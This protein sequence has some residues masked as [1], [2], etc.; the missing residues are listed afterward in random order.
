M[1]LIRAEFENF[2]LLRDLV[3]DFSVDNVRKLTVIRAQNA[4]G[5]TTILNA[6]QWAL[7]GDDALPEKGKNY[8]MSPID[9]D[10]SYSTHVPISVQVDFVTTK[11][12][13]N[14]NGDSFEEKKRYRIIR[15]TYETLNATMHSRSDSI[16]KLLELT[17][18]GSQPIELAQAKIDE[19]LPIELREVFFTDGDRA[20]SFIE[21]TES[22]KV[23]RERVQN[24][25][26]SLLGLE[27]I[28]NALRHLDRTTSTFTKEVGKI[29][30]DQEIKETAE[31]LEEIRKN[32]EELEG[33]IK[34]YKSQCA[35]FEDKIVDT[36]DKID[37]ALEK[38]DQ[39][40]LK[41][42]IEQLK[43]QL[44][45]IDNDRVEANN[46]HSQ[47][48]KSLALS[49]ELLT[50]VLEKSIKKLDKL[51]EQGK[52]PSM[53]IPVLQECLDTNICICG[54]S[55]DPSNS[56]DKCRIEHIYN[57]IKENQEADEVQTTLTDLFFGSKP[58]ELE[59]GGKDNSWSAKYV[60]I[61]KKHSEL[62]YISAE[63]GTKLKNFEADLDNLPDTNIKGL[64]S[65][66][67]KYSD[68]R[69]NL[70]A[71][72]IQS[73]T[74]LEEL[75]KKREPLTKE[76]YSLLGKQKKGAYT[77]ARLN[78]AE[79]VKK[80]LL[81]SRNRIR[82]EE[83]NK[84]SKLM[85]RL[86]LEM[87]GTD[88][89][90]NSIIQK[91]EISEE[92]DILV[93]GPNNNS[94]NPD[95]DLNGASR[96][97]LTLAFILALTKVSEVEA[98]NVIDTPLGMMAGYV[99][100]SVLKTTIRESSQLILFLTSSEIADCEEILDSEAGQV[101]TL[102]NPDHYPLMLINDPQVKELKV[103]R[104]QCNHRQE[105]AICMRKKD[106]EDQNIAES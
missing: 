86:F 10:T 90:Q 74:L 67:Q 64:R 16:A 11:F 2:R 80:V 99:K 87:I 8:R 12:L 76:F 23:K 62:E 53:T 19:E 59:E 95:Q 63:L 35:E 48:F 21:A 31:E 5:K 61:V 66:K 32:T 13:E 7:Y 69:D 34:D 71:K 30:T 97:A 22:T 50:P 43:S 93:Y 24:A 14:Q 88:P 92:F 101:I 44:K 106:L 73:E 55:L 72:Q 40:K 68:Q 38:G 49:Q 42:N 70:Y 91:A 81:N 27:V 51:H 84:V 26:Q 56:N 3:L 78:V 75:N 6:L 25:I 20:L 36:Q 37:L 58:S 46:E 29:D 96:R 65:T 85:N 82:N 60:E 52:L 54:A 103:L 83:L 79:D 105:C 57:L 41:S 15:S 45:Q 18:K 77:Q 98:P 89:K 47:L 4:T 94:L 9:W 28:E 104:C 33:K 39:E 100:K 1:K 102:T 17:E